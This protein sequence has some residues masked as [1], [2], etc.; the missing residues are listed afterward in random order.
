MLLLVVGL[1][2][3]NSGKTVF[4]RAL[5]R[6]MAHRK[7]EPGVFK[8][9]SAHNYWDHL[10]HS[11]RCMEL[12]RLV[13]RDALELQA[14]A[15]DRTP[16]EV[17]NPHHQLFCPL[18]ILKLWEKK[19]GVTP[20]GEDELL[21]ERMTISGPPRSTLWVNRDADVFLAEEPFLKAFE[22]GVQEVRPLNPL[23]SRERLAVAKEAIESCYALQRQDHE[24]LIVE[25]TNDIALP[26]GVKVGEVDVVVVLSANTVLCYEGSVFFRPLRLKRLTRVRDFLAFADPVLGYRL[27]YIPD[28]ERSDDDRIYAYLG[29]AAAGVVDDALSRVGHRA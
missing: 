10:S 23:S 18:D 26:S 3:Y 15:Q 29:P 27:P 24:H 5:A 8:P 9:Q 11:R 19:P 17:I 1:L 4:A 13:S 6:E 28:E 21:A 12:G 20:T 16:I 22:R 14:A 25:S 2:T 7:M